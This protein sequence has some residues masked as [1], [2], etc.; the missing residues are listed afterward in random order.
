MSLHDAMVARQDQARDLIEC[1]NS[2]LESVQA[3]A[4]TLVPAED[5]AY[6]A[7]ELQGAVCLWLRTNMHDTMRCIVFDMEKKDDAK[8]LWDQLLSRATTTRAALEAL[9][10]VEQYAKSLYDFDFGF[11]ED[12][13]VDDTNE[14]AKV[15]TWGALTWSACVT[16]FSN[17]AET[18]SNADNA[19]ALEHLR[20][21]LGVW[22]NAH[23]DSW[24]RPFDPDA[25]RSFFEI[26]I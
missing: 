22:R 10:Q 19:T 4:E 8:R 5:K 21:A 16:F 11:T 12:T 17:R 23:K 1:F 2:V 20:E 9:C 25:C 15:P 14:K 18:C 3:Y 6:L 7:P 24:I 13:F 26:K